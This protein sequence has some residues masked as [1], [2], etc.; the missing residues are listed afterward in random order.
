MAKFMIAHLD[1]GRYDAAR[2]LET[3]T[4]R[5]MH[6]RLWTQDPRVN[7]FAHG[8]AET[9]LNGQRLL[10]HEGEVPGNGCSALM[11]LPEHRVGLYV[12][13]NGMCDMTT[14]TRLWHAF[15][16]RYYPAPTAALVQPVASTQA[17][18]QGLAGS[19]RSTRRS[20]TSFSKLLVL[21]DGPQG[22]ITVGVGEDGTLRTEGLERR[23][24]ILM[25]L[26]PTLARGQ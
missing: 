8:F 22:E 4:V 21:F 3:A 20:V 13:Y 7:G 26:A 5:Q 12:A 24:S 16:D 15:L 2:I 9:T 19:Y 10:R 11:L 17:D 18:L 14:G 6:M 1:G 23:S 25:P